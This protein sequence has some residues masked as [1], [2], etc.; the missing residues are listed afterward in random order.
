MVPAA[1][2]VGLTQLVRLNPYLEGKTQKSKWLK[3]VIFIFFGLP[4][5]I[6]AQIP[7]AFFCVYALYVPEL[8][9]SKSFASGNEE[10]LRKDF[11]DALEREK[12]R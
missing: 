10:E 6:I 8:S 9:K 4:I 5:L 7:D 3:V 1:Y 2:L 12:E 11:L